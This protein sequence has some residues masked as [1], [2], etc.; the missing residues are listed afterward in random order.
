MYQNNLV[1]ADYCTIKNVKNMKS[2]FLLDRI[3]PIGSHFR[4]SDR[5]EASV[6]SY[7]GVPS[8]EGIGED[9]STSDCIFNMSKLSQ[10]RL[11]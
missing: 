5:V 2:L 7:L 1:S 9:F 11:T 6:K 3:I 4:N 8:E 10:V